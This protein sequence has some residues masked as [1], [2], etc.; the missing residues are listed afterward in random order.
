MLKYFFLWSMFLYLCH[1][2]SSLTVVCLLRVHIVFDKMKF[3]GLF[4]IDKKFLLIFFN[5]FL[6]ILICLWI[7][8]G[9]NALLLTKFLLVLFMSVLQQYF[10][11]SVRLARSYLIWLFYFLLESFFV[12]Y[13]IEPKWPFSIYRMEF[14]RDQAWNGNPAY[15]KKYL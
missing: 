3:L 8:V 1:D 6:Q 15:L 5:S 7:K 10:L 2:V 4:S 12:I 9:Q 11:E 14:I 13:L